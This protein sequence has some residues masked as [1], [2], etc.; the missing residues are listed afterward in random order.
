MSRNSLGIHSSEVFETI[1]EQSNDA[2][3]LFT[4]NAQLFYANSKAKT[5]INLHTA[6][7]NAHASELLPK[8]LFRQL[9]ESKPGQS[10]QIEFRCDDVGV[11]STGIQWLQSNITQIQIDNSMFQQLTLKD[12][13]DSKQKESVLLHQATTDDLSGLSNRRRLRKVLDDKTEQEICVAIVDVDH[14]KSI[15]DKFGH[16]VGD[17]AIRFVAAKML[18]HFSDALC[19]ARLGGEEFAVVLESG[20]RTDLINQVDSFRESVLSEPF[21]DNQHE[22][23]VSIGMAFSDSCGADVAN[24]LNNADKALYSSKDSGRNCLT[25][26]Q[27]A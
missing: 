26:H 20:N 14:F 1:V 5:I 17:S 15:N 19:V 2:I 24:L 21:S 8:L 25:V 9:S 16:A 11:C 18:D 13:T 23:T 12:V 27:E 4:S 10:E 7:L 3:L 22:I 6:H